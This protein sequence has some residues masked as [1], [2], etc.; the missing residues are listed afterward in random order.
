[1]VMRMKKAIL[2]VAGIFILVAG[3]STK[4]SA[5]SMQDEI[6]QDC[7]ESVKEC[8]D[9]YYSEE[10]QDSIGKIYKD[11]NTP[12]YIP[13]TTTL[14]IN[15]ELQKMGIEFADLYDT[16]PDETNRKIILFGYNFSLL[17][18]MQYEN[19]AMKTDINYYEDIQKYYNEFIA[20]P[21]LE[22]CS[23]FRK[24]I[25][26][27]KILKYA[28]SIETITERELAKEAYEQIQIVNIKLNYAIN[29][30]DV[31]IK[32]SYNAFG[33]AASALLKIFDQE[34]AYAHLRKYYDAS[35]ESTWSA[36]KSLNE[37]NKNY[38]EMLS[39]SENDMNDLYRISGQAVL[40]NLAAVLPIV[41]DIYTNTEIIK[42]SNAFDGIAVKVD[43]QP[44]SLDKV[45][46]SGNGKN[47]EMW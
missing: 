26:E 32:N 23:D 43:I 27:N 24:Y 33:D 18:E 5:E 11:Y 31:D 17:T 12:Q 7:Y 46:I 22:I 4:I 40:E 37:A 10:Y 38:V 1:M 25:K 9:T 47:N 8:I 30:F 13:Y 42:D 16:Y 15:R 45:E 34:D 20:A 39:Y 3:I 2:L 14:A 41:S 28:D 44:T 29:M 21:S 35:K 36:R 6:S 19:S